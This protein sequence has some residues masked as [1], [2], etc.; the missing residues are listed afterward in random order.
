MGNKQLSLCKSSSSSFL[1]LST[2]EQWEYSI[3]HKETTNA[4][5]WRPNY[6]WYYG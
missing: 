2:T 6:D 5:W 3:L 4:F 1:E